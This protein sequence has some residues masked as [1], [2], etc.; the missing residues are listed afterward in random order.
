MYIAV[1]AL[2]FFTILQEELLLMPVLVISTLALV[3][4]NIINHQ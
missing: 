4:H 2:E 3:K 1:F